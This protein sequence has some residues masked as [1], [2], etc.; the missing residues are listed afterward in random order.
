[1]EVERRR[2]RK[3][4]VV[5]P[6][7]GLVGGGERFASEVT[8]RLAQNEGYEIHVFANRWVAG[9]DRV[10]FHKVPIV[11]FP[12][13]LG[14]LV[15]AWCVQWKISRMHFDLV[16][17][18]H[19]IFHADI[20][21]AHGVPHAG[22]VRNV[23][24]RTP[25]LYDRAVTFVERYLIRNGASSCF[26]PV[27]SIAMETFRSEYATLPGRWQVVPPGV[28]VARFSTPDRTA[29]RNEIRGRYRLDESDMLLLFVG[30][31]FEVKGLDT[32]I[33]ALAKARS[34]QSGMNIRLLVVGRGNE[35]KYRKMAESL[36]IAQAV[37]FAGT[38]VDR[39]ERYY[40]A[41]DVFILLSRFDTF[42]MV[43]LEA[44]AAGLPVIVS[45]N[46][47]AK[48]LVE[49]GV[50]GFILREPSDADS[51]ADRM[52]RLLDRTRREAMG[53]AAGQTAAMHDWEKLTDK[54][55]KIYES[56]FIQSKSSD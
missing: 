8:E 40:R 56:F 6:K 1:M 11:R 26:L 10:K 48:D 49:E 2:R 39:L 30:M 47:G 21:S 54:M 20:Y 43:V 45:P 18:H 46:V 9:S 37:T 31:N 36:G 15:F 3:I 17:S 12:R 24:N 53:E 51:A 22:W 25:S 4:A 28:E 55:E 35:N 7:Y 42:G 14:P 13:F 33:A 41:A 32:I 29:C 50:N 27:S 34:V 16:H 5:V 19:W 52:V 23:R 38:Q 44:M